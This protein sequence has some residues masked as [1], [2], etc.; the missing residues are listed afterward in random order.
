MN[1]HFSSRI[2]CKV[3]WDYC[4]VYIKEELLLLNPAFFI[5]IGGCWFQEIFKLNCLLLKEHKLQKG[6]NCPSSIPYEEQCINWYLNILSF[7]HSFSLNSWI[8]KSAFKK[9]NFKCM[10]GKTINWFLVSVSS[11]WPTHSVV[12]MI[13]LTIVSITVSCAWKICVVQILYLNFYYYF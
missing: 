10:R 4:W 3:S 5:S 11:S 7:G 13:Y 6:Y 12:R 1:R 2:A 8:Q 9:K